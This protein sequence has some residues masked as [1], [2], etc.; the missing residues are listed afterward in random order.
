MEFSQNE[1]RTLGN[2]FTNCC[3]GEDSRREDVARCGDFRLSRIEMQS[4]SPCS[5]VSAMVINIVAAYMSAT[6]FDCWYLPTYFGEIAKSYEDAPKEQVGVATTINMC[7]LQR[8]HRRL[9]QC[10]KIFIPL[11]DESSEHWY[12]L[13]MNL[14]ERKGELWDSKPESSLADGRMS[15]VVRAI[16]LLQKVFGNEMT[17][18]TDV[19]LH[20]PSFNVYIPEGNPTHDNNYDSGIFVIR[21]MQQH[22]NN[23]YTHVHIGDLRKRIALDIVNNPGNSIIHSKVTS[24]PESSRAASH[25][26]TELKRKQVPN[27]ETPEGCDNYDDVFAL[28]CSNGPTGRKC[29]SHRLRR[30]RA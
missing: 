11:H 12:L 14:G 27:W 4:L 21:H 26:V 1:M 18:S 15:L 22:D 19:Y 29:R 3:S 10:T 28:N 17:R 20:F 25:N 5:Q 16:A 9:H 13:V 2:L 7:R 8:F 24:E 23:W 6:E 30:S